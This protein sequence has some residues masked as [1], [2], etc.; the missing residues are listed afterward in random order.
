MIDGALLLR[1]Q[2][3]AGRG[4]EPV[5]V[6]HAARLPLVLPRSRGRATTPTAACCAR[7]P[8]AL[9]VTAGFVAVFAV[10]GYVIE[11][12]SR[13]GPRR[14]ALRDDRHRHRTRA[15]RRSRCCA[16]TNRSSA[17]P[18]S[19]KG[20]G[21]RELSSMFLFG[22][23]YAV[24]SLGCTIADV[25]RARR[26]RRSATRASSPVSRCSSSYALGMGSLVVFLTIATAL[27]EDVGGAVACAGCCPSCT[28]SLRSS[29]SRPGSTSR[30]TGGTSCASATRSDV[31][32]SSTTSP[33][34]R[35][36]STEL[37]RGRRSDP[38]GPRARARDPGRCG[39]AVAQSTTTPQPCFVI[40]SPGT[41]SRSSRRCAA[42]SG[43]S[44]STVARSNG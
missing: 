43:S 2:P 4:G 35:P 28:A 38:V 7:S 30:T 14:A 36:G 18:S 27:G 34:V 26:P 5:R 20:A 33:A 1:L 23:S 12:V 10:I 24:A 13:R 29:C 19:Q 11:N 39:G 37:D 31:T 32:R 16:A 44:R 22:V 42:R 21:S 3:R 9:T 25:P 41:T 17:C 8:S 15:A 6:R 40:S